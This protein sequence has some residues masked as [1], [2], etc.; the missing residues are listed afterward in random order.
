LRKRRDSLPG[1]R[2][3]GALGCV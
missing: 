2:A 1:F 3:L